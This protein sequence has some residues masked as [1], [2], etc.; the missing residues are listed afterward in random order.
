[1]KYMDNASNSLNDLKL[2]TMLHNVNRLSM[3]HQEEYAKGLIS[4][5]ELDNHT[6][7]LKAAAKFIIAK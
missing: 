5:T 2:I 1:M 7:I 3:Q 4:Q 6:R